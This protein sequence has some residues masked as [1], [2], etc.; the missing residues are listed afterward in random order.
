LR[1][2]V[3]IVKREIENYDKDDTNHRLLIPSLNVPKNLEDGE[4]VQK[5][6]VGRKMRIGGGEMRIPCQNEKQGTLSNHVKSYH[7]WGLEVG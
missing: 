4:K 7:Q 3:D 6:I 1:F 5:G 2:N